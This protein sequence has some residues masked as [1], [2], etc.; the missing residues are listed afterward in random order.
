MSVASCLHQSY[1]KF[2]KSNVV[3]M[4]PY[5]AI[6]FKYINEMFLVVVIMVP[7]NLS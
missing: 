3:L 7:H 5:Y 4:P 2:R 1:W 6:P